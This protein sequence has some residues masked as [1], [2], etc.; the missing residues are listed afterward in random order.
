MGKSETLELYLALPEEQRS[1][2]LDDALKAI[3]GKVLAVLGLLDFDKGKAVFSVSMEAINRIARVFGG[4]PLVLERDGDKFVV[5]VRELPKV[6]PAAELLAAGVRRG[7]D[8]GGDSGDSCGSEHSDG[9]SDPDEDDDD[10][11]DYCRHHVR[12]EWAGY[13]RT[14]SDAFDLANEAN[15]PRRGKVLKWRVRFD[16]DRR[17]FQYRGLEKPALVDGALISKKALKDWM[18]VVNASKRR[19]ERRESLRREEMW[20][21]W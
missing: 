16:R 14:I 11:P 15:M 21:E 5:R 18:S 4:S 8:G 17:V 10:G 3:R 1:P 13:G 20:G 19:M 7:G 6:V 9:C 2:E 12:G